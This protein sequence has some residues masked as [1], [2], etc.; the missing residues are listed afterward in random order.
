[1]ALVVVFKL[2]TDDTICLPP[3]S[4]VLLV[5]RLLGINP[6]AL[7]LHLYLT[8]FVTLQKVLADDSAVTGNYRQGIASFCGH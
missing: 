7:E 3:D 4:L 8:M 2:A 6:S 1:M 5:G